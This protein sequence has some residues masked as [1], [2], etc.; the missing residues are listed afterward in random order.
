MGLWES[1][2]EAFNLILLS[3]TQAIG[4]G[5]LAKSSLSFL[6]SVSAM[7]RAAM[8]AGA[9]A[10]WLLGPNEP[11]DREGRW[12]AH[13]E[14][15]VSARERLERA[16]RQEFSGKPPSTIVREFSSAVR[17]KLPEGTI[18]P[19]QVPKFDALLKSIGASEKYIVYASLSQ[20][21]HAT[22]HGAGIFRQHL[23]FQKTYGEFITPEDWWL[24]LSTCWWFL[25]TPLASLAKRCAITE[26]QLLPRELQEK[27]VAAQK[28]FR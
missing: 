2:V 14:T 1:D 12:L 21:A 4:S 16:L 26:P 23:G 8:E 11:F 9:R 18:V 28:S 20:T 19:K 6:P 24:P 27:F 22:H 5:R 7:A 13:L 3:A 25:A 17:A 15:E 10:M